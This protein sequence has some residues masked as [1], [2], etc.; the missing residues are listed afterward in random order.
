MLENLAN[1]QWRYNA[2][3]SNEFL[4][5]ERTLAAYLSAKKLLTEKIQIQAGLRYEH[6]WTESNQLTQRQIS[7]SHYGR[8]Y[9]TLHLNW[10]LKGNQ[11][12]AF[13]A[14]WGIERPDFN[15]LNPFRIYT[16]TTDYMT[17]KPLSRSCLYS[18]HGDKLQQWERTLCRSLQQSWQ[19]GDRL[20][21][22]IPRKRKSGNRSL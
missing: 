19:R 6:T 21:N 5:K 7:R 14:N 18:Q 10:Q 17:G 9:P 12:M 8:F 20:E 13:A 3:E 11:N 4:Y 2:D 16:S 1:G 15:D 22:H